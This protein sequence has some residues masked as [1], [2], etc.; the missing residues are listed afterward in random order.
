MNNPTEEIKLLPL[1]IDVTVAYGKY[2]VI[3]E[4]QMKNFRALRYGEEWRSLTGDNLVMYLALELQ[5]LRN[6]RTLAPLPQPSEMKSAANEDAIKVP[7]SVNLAA[8]LHYQYPATK[9]DILLR[10]LCESIASVHHPKPPSECKVDVLSSSACNLGT[11][12]CSIKHVTQPTDEQIEGIG[13]VF[14]KQI[15]DCYIPASAKLDGEDI[16]RMEQLFKQAILSALALRDTTITPIDI[17]IK[18]NKL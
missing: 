14:I 9:G 16:R 5:E 12:G 4:A 10:E 2:R 3:A 17:Y 13:K 8:Y 7:T 18:Q 6:I 1:D 15:A 11:C